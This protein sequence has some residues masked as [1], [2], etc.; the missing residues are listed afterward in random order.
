MAMGVRPPTSG[1]A[2]GMRHNRSRLSHGG[3]PQAAL[4]R[5][6]GPSISRRTGAFFD[7]E[8]ER[9]IMV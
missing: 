3:S 2:A 6:I 1:G 7:A 8:M 4:L 5:P 9:Q